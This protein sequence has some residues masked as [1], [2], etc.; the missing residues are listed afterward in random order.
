MRVMPEDRTFWLRRQD[1][2][3]PFIFY[4]AKD[5]KHYEVVLT[6]MRGTSVKGY[7]LLPAE[8]TGQTGSTAA[9]E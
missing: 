5:A 2:N 3:A 6:A 9:G 4:G 7:V 1:V 8:A